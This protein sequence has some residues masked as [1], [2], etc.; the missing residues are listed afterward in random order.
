MSNKN[1]NK[2]YIVQQRRKLVRMKHPE[3]NVES[4]K[5]NSQK[6]GDLNSIIIT[7]PIDFYDYEDVEDSLAGYPEQHP[8]RRWGGIMPNIDLR[9][10]MM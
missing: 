8:N 9:N 5:K 10:I 4:S 3:E 1:K 2:K 7:A 6:R